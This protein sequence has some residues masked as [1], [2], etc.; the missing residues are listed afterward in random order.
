MDAVTAG[1]H[2]LRC[3]HRLHLQLPLPLSLILF[4]SS[5]SE[6]ICNDRAGFWIRDGGRQV[7]KT[8]ERSGSD[9]NA[10]CGAGYNATR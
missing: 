7:L 2:R 3:R 1:D 10:G 6:W 8:S 9:N 5:Q 4:S